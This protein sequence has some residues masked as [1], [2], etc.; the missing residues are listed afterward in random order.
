MATLKVTSTSDSM[1][2]RSI[3][4]MR[5]VSLHVSMRIKKHL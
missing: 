4:Q 3:S 5:Y 2:R 1:E